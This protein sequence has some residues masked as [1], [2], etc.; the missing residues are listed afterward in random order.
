MTDPKKN[1][2]AAESKKTGEVTT[3]SGEKVKATPP[4][5]NTP[6]GTT[7]EEDAPKDLTLDEQE[8]LVGE[9]EPGETGWVELDKDGKPKGK[10]KRGI[11]P[12]DTPVAAVLVSPHFI[13]N[14]ITTPA[15]APLTNKMNTSPD[16]MSAANRDSDQEKRDYA[17]IAKRRKELRHG[18]KSE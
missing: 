10:A 17:D 12:A 13:R 1:D 16:L 4:A 14:I 15:G 18:I 3:E 9:L 2:P 7:A 5:I 11:P 8:A 6:V